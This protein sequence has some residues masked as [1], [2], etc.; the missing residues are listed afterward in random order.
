MTAREWVDSVWEEEPK[1]ESIIKTCLF[2]PFEEKPDWRNKLFT[3]AVYVSVVGPLD[4]YF[5]T[6]WP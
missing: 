4:D 1:L 2:H 5:V 3:Q 6:K